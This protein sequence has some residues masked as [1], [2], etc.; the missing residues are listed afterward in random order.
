MKVYRI[1]VIVLAIVLG[2]S[3]STLLFLHP[4]TQVPTE[5]HYE[6]L[7]ENALQVA[8]TLDTNVVNDENLTAQLSFNEK[9]LS[10]TVRA[11]KATVTAW[12]PISNYVLEI[13]NGTMKFQGTLNY[14]EIQYTKLNHNPPQWFCIIMCIATGGVVGLSVYYIFF[15]V[16]KRF[17]K[18]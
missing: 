11:R 14:E 17:K 10:V 16:W 7:Q 12:V 2:I 18:R 5:A 1:I 6:H 8:K 4:D 15:G 13:E 9:Q 3:V